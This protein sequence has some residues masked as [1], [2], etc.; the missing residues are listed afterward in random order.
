MMHL[1]IAYLFSLVANLCTLFITVYC[2]NTLTS[3]FERLHQFI[4]ISNKACFFKKIPFSHRIK[5]SLGQ[6]SLMHFVPKFGLKFLKSLCLFYL[7]HLENNTY[8]SCYLVSKRQF[9]LYS[10]FCSIFL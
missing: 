10:Y 8:M 3:T 6:L 7:F 4:I 5:T 1:K 9:I 2:L